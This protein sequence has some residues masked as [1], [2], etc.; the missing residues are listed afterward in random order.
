VLEA[1]PAAQP[2]IARQSPSTAAAGTS[3]PHIRDFSAARI[4]LSDLEDKPAI[5]ETEQIVVAARI[6]FMGRLQGKVCSA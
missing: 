1:V 3:V 2:A 4:N 5:P 6:V